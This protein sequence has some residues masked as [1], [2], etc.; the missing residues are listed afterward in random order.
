MIANLA[1]QN[2]RSKNMRFLSSRTILD[3]PIIK[4]AGAPASIFAAELNTAGAPLKGK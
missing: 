3:R 2:F 1:Q 4:N